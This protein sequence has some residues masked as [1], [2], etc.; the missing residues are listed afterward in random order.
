MRKI[1]ILLG[2]LGLG[3]MPAQAQLSPGTSGFSSAPTAASDAEYWIMMRTLGACLADSKHD[4]SVAFLASIPGSPAE[5]AAF[6]TLFHRNTNRCMGNFVSASM[7]RAH[8]RGL[9]AEGLFEQMAE[10]RRRL[11]LAADRP[12]PEAVSSLHDFAACYVA[13]HQAEAIQFLEETKVGTKG[14]VAAIRQMA[15]DFGPCLPQGVEVR[16]VPVNIRMAVAEALYRAANG[17]P[18]LNIQVAQ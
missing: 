13:G 2:V 7:R 16:I 8:L 11:G 6:E 10:D 15:A 1:L 12:A 14:E 3:A 18:D 5:D 4:Q 9:V 17:L